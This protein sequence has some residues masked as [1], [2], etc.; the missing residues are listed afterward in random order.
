MDY[1]SI[2]ESKYNRTNWQKLLYDIFRQNIR[3]WQQPI[4]VSVDENMAKTALYIGQISLPDGHGI[5]VY[6]VE[7]SDKVVIER[8]RAGIRNLLCTNWRGIG[9]AGAFMFCYRQNESVLR[10]SYVSEA[11]SFTEDGSLKKESTDTKRFT[12]LLGE[13]HRSRTAIDQFEKLKKSS[14]GLKDVTKAFSVEALSDSFFKEYKKQYEDIVE[15]VTGKR[16]IKGA[17]NKWKEEVTGESC[18]EIMREFAAFPDAEKAV[19]DYVKKLM[20]RLVFIQFLQKKGWMGCPAGE[21]WKNGDSEFVQNLFANTP[22]KE[23]FVD[24]VLEPLFNDINTKRPGDLTSSPHVGVNIKIPYLNGGL[25]E[26]DDYDSTNFPL[27]AKYMKSMLDFFASYNFTIDE[28]DPDDAEIGVDPEMLGRIFENL[29]EDNKDKGAFY[30]PKEIVQ[31]MCRE[32]LIAYLQTDITEDAVKDSI[33]QFVTS[34]DVSPLDNEL[35]QTIDKKLKEVKI[36]DP[37]IGSGAFPMGLLRELYACRKAIEGIDDETAVGIKTHIIQNNIYGVDIEKGAV[38]IARLRFWLAL[39]VDEQ[40]PHALPNMDFKIMQ[41]NSLLEQYEGVDLSGMSLNEQLKKKSRSKKQKAW[42]QTFA[43]DERIAL[44][45]IQHAIHEYYLTDDHATKKNLRS[46]I[47]ENV[48]SYILNLKGCTSDIQQKLENLPIPNDQFF[49][50]H[51]YFKDV[52]DKGGFDIVI[53]NP[54]YINAIELKKQLGPEKYQ[55]LKKCFTTAKGATDFYVYFF[56][57]GLNLLCD[58][59][60]LCYITP[61]K[62]LCANYAVEF[63]KLLIKETQIISF[64][65]VSNTQCFNASVYPIVTHLRKTGRAQNYV[66]SVFARDN[67]TLRYLSSQLSL[68]PE[69]LLGFLL[70]DKIE[71]INSLIDKSKKLID[72]CE[73]NAT[74]TAGEA[75]KFHDYIEEDGDGFQLINTGTIDPYV[76]LWGIRQLTDKGCKYLRP[77]LAKSREKIGDNRYTMYNSTKIIFAKM[78]GKVEAF[79]DEDGEYASINTNCIHSIKVN[80]KLLLGWLHSKVFNFIYDV[81]FDGLRMAGG[82]LPFSAPYLSC[83][84]YPQNIDSAISEGVISLVDHILSLKKENP[85]ADTSALE[86]EIDHLVYQLYGLTDEEI[87]IIENS[88]K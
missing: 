20:G 35:K 17:N 80:N 62:Y 16:M 65:D 10:F 60:C 12:Y 30:T 70:S 15:F 25:F 86:A 85:Y 39:I 79:L 32:S 74:S 58:K 19:R 14:L 67:K 73:I 56:E 27:P 59:G 41:G 50:W 1:R 31:Y 36:C 77:T 45:N 75:D 76:S 53:G 18:A 8:N 54:P 23:T 42:Q 48:R 57:K 55:Q 52:F 4:E 5:A 33:R 71:V 7:L 51:I 34:Y 21:A 84:Y 72:V 87:A 6:E 64:W 2:I 3:F 11:L 61:N 66:F 49:L 24:D 38:D 83:M 47:N 43:F 44:D 46:A 13:G 82:Y 37:A 63:R 40:N 26:N 88:T 81:F 9:C 22:Y 69:N 68:L 28:N 29:L 78:A